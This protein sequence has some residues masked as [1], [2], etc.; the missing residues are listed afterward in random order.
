MHDVCVHECVSIPKAYRFECNK[1]QCVSESERKTCDY[2]KN[3]AHFPLV[4]LN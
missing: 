4:F 1:K 2:N 3:G